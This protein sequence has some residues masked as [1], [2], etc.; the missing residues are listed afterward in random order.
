MK[1]GRKTITLFLS[2]LLLITSFFVVQAPAFSEASS[3]QE[4]PSA[5]AYDQKVISRVDS[6][7]IFRDIH[8]LSET[9]GPRV[10]GTEEEK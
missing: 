10:T 4:N 3:K 7:R 5:K 9:I 1:K 2:A 6:E 8:Y